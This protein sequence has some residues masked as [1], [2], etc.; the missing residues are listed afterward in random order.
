VLREDVDQETGR[1]LLRGTKRP[2]RWR[3]VPIVTSWQKSLL[4]YAVK[5]AEGVDGNRLFGSWS[6]IRRDLAA[7]CKAAEIAPCSPN[8]LRRPHSHWLRAEGVPLE[9]V[10]PMMGHSS[11]RMVQTVYGKLSADELAARLRGV[12]PGAPDCIAGASDR[13]DPGGLPG[14]P[15][16]QKNREKDRGFSVPRDGIEPPTRGFSIPCS[17]N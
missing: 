12:I 1:V 15:K 5:F 7:A 17:T 10:A 9:L 2:T 11:T 14:R 8:D 3:T 4:A 13:K 6:N 16:K